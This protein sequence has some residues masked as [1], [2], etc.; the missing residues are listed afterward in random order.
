MQVEGIETVSVAIS[1]LRL[2]L[3]ALCKGT[4]S[5]LISVRTD[6]AQTERKIKQHQAQIAR[7]QSRT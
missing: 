7:G 5:M 1:A 3:S 4:T 6:A 2:S